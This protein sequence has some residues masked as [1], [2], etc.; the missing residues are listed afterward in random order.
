M[1]CE[2]CN[3][4]F[5]PHDHRQ[6]YCTKRCKLNSPTKKLTTQRYQQGR[7]EKINEYKTTRGCCVCGYSAHPAALHFDHVVGEKSFNISGDPKKAWNLI[8]A[9]MAKCRV[10]CA[11][12]HSI[13]T[14]ELNE[15][16]SKR[17]SNR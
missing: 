12:C 9:E 2:T 5:V 17:K 1:I 11:N 8:E 16:H 10:I 14:Y 15:Y 4:E 6:K 7:R 13:K 3:C